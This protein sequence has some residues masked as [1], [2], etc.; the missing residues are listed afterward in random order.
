[1]GDRPIYDEQVEVNKKEN[2]IE[3][4]VEKKWLGR[5]LDKVSGWFNDPDESRNVFSTLSAFIMSTSVYMF[6][7][8]IDS[9]F[10]LGDMW[11][12]GT[13]AVGFAGSLGVPAVQEDGMVKGYIK[14]LLN[15]L[16]KKYRKENIEISDKIND[17]EFRRNFTRKHNEA[18]ITELLEKATVDTI[19]DLEDKIFNIEDSLE[20]ETKTKTIDKLKIQLLHVKNELENIQT[21]GISRNKI[22]YTNIEIDDI[23]NFVE[24]TVK[25]G[26][27]K[28]QDTSTAR[29]RK[30]NWL[31]RI[32][33]P[34]LSIILLYAAKRLLSLNPLEIISATFI[35]LL[36]LIY[37]WYRA[38]SKRIELK[39]SIAIPAERERNTLLKEAE[40]EYKIW[41]KDI[42]LAIEEK[43]KMNELHDLALKLDYDRDKAIY[44]E[45][46]KLEEKTRLAKEK[47]EA[48]EKEKLE[49]E[50]KPKTKE[51]EE[52]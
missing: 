22:T 7:Q 23:F 45:K 41:N 15:P 51:N 14:F 43:E 49:K 1:M 20:I 6:V 26:K 31:A 29:Q 27:E 48:E 21:N 3:D 18:N 24:K 37:T 36:I 8:G 5:N 19:A 4:N 12:W 50:E 11:S 25:V 42:A 39:E 30:S 47:L 46:I 38:Y 32:Y 9:G 40:E 13:V 44:D 35:F 10:V 16:F 17:R 28:L 34:M 52:K 2:L 33:M